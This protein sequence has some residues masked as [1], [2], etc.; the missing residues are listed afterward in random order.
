MVHGPVRAVVLA[1]ALPAAYESACLVRCTDVTRLPGR[2]RPEWRTAPAP[3]APVATALAEF[4]QKDAAVRLASLLTDLGYTA[5]H[6]VRTGGGWRRYHVH[7]VLVPESQRIPTNQ[8]MAAAWRQGRQALLGTDPLGSSSPRHAQRIILARAG[9]QAALLAG[10]RRLGA[11]L[12]RIRLGD[13]E[14]AA[15]LVRA[16]RLVGVTAEVT[17]RPG[18]LLVTVSAATASRLL[19]NPDSAAA[20]FRARDGDSPR[21]AARTC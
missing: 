1:D 4:D 5:S 17:R 11:D 7:R 3:V 6:E 15:V 16:A 14:M 20:P 18:C 13:H 2:R 9:W 10:G 8:M 21:L 19:V 12:L